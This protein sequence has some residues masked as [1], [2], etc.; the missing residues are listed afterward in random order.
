MN[1]MERVQLLRATVPWPSDATLAQ[2]RTRLLTAAAT[3]HE[4]GQ[5]TSR[6]ASLPWHQNPGSPPPT[7]FGATNG[8]LPHANVHGTGSRSPAGLR[9]ARFRPAI[10]IGLAAAVA[11]GVTG[12]ALT[13]HTTPA[14]HPP[15]AGPRPTSHP[16]SHPATSSAVAQATLAAKI[17]RAAAAH[18]ERSGVTTEPAPGQ[19]IYAKTESSGAPGTALTTNEN[20]ITFDGSQSAYYNTPGSPLTVHTSPVAAPG[21]NVPPWTA[22]NTT[23]TP[24]TAYDVL[25]SL[26]AD[27]RQLLAEIDKQLA[28]TNAQNIAA[29]NPLSGTAPK[30]QAQ[31]EFDYLTL[32]LWNAAGGV[33]GPPAVEAAAYR[34]LATLPG[35][36]VQQ[37]VTDILGNQAIAVSD[38]GGY[39]QLLLD[40]QTY[41]VIGLRQ[42][43]TGMAPN[44]APGHPSKL[45]KAQRDWILKHDGTIIGGSPKGTVTQTPAAPPK[46]TVTETLL[47]AQVTE[48]P[49]PGQK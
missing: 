34:A 44:A 7:D 26:P 43:S 17:L 12:Y 10:A 20:W 16:A 2:G 46:G 19:W 18:I 9:R 25:A 3:E 42:L 38:D 13:R 14:T 41:Q 4:A 31:R 40:P 35:I 32:I 37:G 47:Y 8:S 5:H 36:W 1:D 30:T 22:W 21:P 33:G 6:T 39:D 23:A 45:S 28:G 27:P 24:K 29:G 11:V 15:I 48:V 49:A